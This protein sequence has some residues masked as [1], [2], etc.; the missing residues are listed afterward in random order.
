MRRLVVLAAVVLVALAPAAAAQTADE[1]LGG[2]VGTANG[3]AFS[4]LPIFPGLLPTGDAPFEVTGALTTASIKSGGNAYGQ[5]APLWPG[6]AA[7]NLGPLLGTAASQPALVGLFPPY[8]AAVTA[9]QDSGEESQG[10]P[11]GPVMKASGKDGTSDSTV[12]AG[13]VDV[14]GVFHADAVRS[15]SRAAV[16]AGKLVTETTATL[17]GIR[18]GD[19]TVTIDALRSTSKA[20]SDGTRSTSTGDTVLTG[21]KVA[22]QA[23]DLTGKGLRSLGLPIEALTKAL[24]GAGIELALTKADGRS[25]G[26]TADRVGSG[27][28]ATIAN[29]AAAANPQFQGS[30]FVVTL[31]PTAVGALASPPFAADV[32]PEVPLPTLEAG[33]GFGSIATTVSGSFGAV[34]PGAPVAAPAS[35]AFR[36][37]KKGLDPTAPVPATAAAGL[38][39]AVVLGSRWISRFA[40]RFVSSE[41]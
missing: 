4:I 3:A 2:Y 21:L 37:A 9:D 30:S 11:P 16:E 29:P 17:T 26:G 7:A 23:A 12:Q 8:P 36:P 1:E 5:A 25:E 32:V 15:T 13:A 27:L 40:G 39:V 33:T 18:L 41:E 35:V 14:P 6:S 22:G 10:A 20:T 24:Q 31:G 19:G 34:P 38:L 28:T